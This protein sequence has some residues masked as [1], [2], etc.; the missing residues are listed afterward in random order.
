MKRIGKEKQMK[1]KCSR[2]HECKD[3]SQ[4]R[5]MAKQNRY[6]SYCRNCER[7]YSREYK[8]YKRGKA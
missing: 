2:C 8:A 4:F 1:R 5:F 6:N 3:E 7:I